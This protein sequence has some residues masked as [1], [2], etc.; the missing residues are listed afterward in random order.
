MGAHTRASSCA[1]DQASALPSCEPGVRPFACAG[2]AAAAAEGWAA[3]AAAA[4]AGGG[5]GSAAAAAAAA[6][7]G[8]GSAAAFED[9]FASDEGPVC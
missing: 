4:A 1:S 6:G 7:G 3:A 9:P 2:A 8:V 5:V